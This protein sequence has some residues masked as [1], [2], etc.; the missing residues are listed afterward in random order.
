MKSSEILKEIWGFTNILRIYHV[1]FGSQ[2]SDQRIQIKELY[3]ESDVQWG[4]WNKQIVQLFQTNKYKYKNTNLDPSLWLLKY[5]TN[6]LVHRPERGW[7]KLQI[8]WILRISQ[9]MGM[10]SVKIS[11]KSED[12]HGLQHKILRIYESSIEIFNWKPKQIWITMYICRGNCF[13]KQKYKWLSFR[14]TLLFTP[15]VNRLVHRIQG[16]FKIGK[17]LVI[18]NTKNV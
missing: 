13:G 4:E 5:E 1:I 7:Q 6:Q 3:S 8:L 11:W 10:K 14:M 2:D 18:D 15:E 12:C 16:E 9:Y 17:Q